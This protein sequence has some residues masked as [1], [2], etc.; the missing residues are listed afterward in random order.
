MRASTFGAIV[1]LSGD[2]GSLL[3]AHRMLSGPRAQ[4]G[5]IHAA[6]DIV[7]AGFAGR[8]ASLL[9]RARGPV[10]DPAWTTRPP[11]LEELVLG[12]MAAPGA[13]QPQRPTIAGNT[14]EVPA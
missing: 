5:E 12:Y 8:Q 9:I 13:A 1:Q 7:Q 3:T 6:H 4:A 11:S 14:E 10:R 2:V